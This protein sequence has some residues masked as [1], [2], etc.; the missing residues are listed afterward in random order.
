VYFRKTF[1]KQLFQ[2]FVLFLC[3]VALLAAATSASAIPDHRPTSVT[4]SDR[5]E[6][7]RPETQHFSINEIFNMFCF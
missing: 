7:R 4:Y 1:A 3:F 2:C 5:Q 6:Q